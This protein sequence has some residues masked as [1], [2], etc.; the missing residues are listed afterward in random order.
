MWK[1]NGTFTQAGYTNCALEYF[2]TYCD[3]KKQLHIVMDIGICQQT[4]N[5]ILL[6][7]KQLSDTV[8][9]LWKHTYNKL[10]LAYYV[11]MAAIPE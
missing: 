2:R 6:H 3:S 10:P 9:L 7:L 5:C 4:I 1:E 8:L 11:V